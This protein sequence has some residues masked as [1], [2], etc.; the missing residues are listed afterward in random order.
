[1]W[2]SMPGGGCPTAKSSQPNRFWGWSYHPPNHSKIPPHTQTPPILTLPA[3][4]NLAMSH[5]ILRIVLHGCRY[6]GATIEQPRGV[7]QRRVWP[8]AWLHSVAPYIISNLPL[9]LNQTAAHI[10]RRWCFEATC[11]GGGVIQPWWGVNQR[12]AMVALQCLWKASLVSFEIP[13]FH[14]PVHIVLG[15]PI[16]ID[17]E[18]ENLSLNSRNNVLKPCVSWV[19]AAP[20]CFFAISMCVHFVLVGKFFGK[21][22]LWFGGVIPHCGSWKFFCH[23]YVCTFCTCWRVFG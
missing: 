7:A 19:F 2:L 23:F 6:W 5:V 8:V 3:E 9:P 22:P 16:Y 1:M 12:A 14:L 18:G 4:S 10:T 15:M 21:L 20:G 17:S 13:K 11:A